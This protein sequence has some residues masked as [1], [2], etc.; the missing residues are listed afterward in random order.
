MGDL[1]IEGNQHVDAGELAEWKEHFDTPGS[2][3]TDQQHDAW[4]RDHSPGQPN[5]PDDKGLTTLKRR[6]DYFL[7]G[8]HVPDRFVVQHMTLAYNLLH[9]SEAFLSDHFGLNVDLYFK[10]PHCNPLDA[11]VVNAS[12]DFMNQGSFRPGQMMWYRFDEPGTYSFRVASPE[13][14]GIAFEV[15]ARTD[16][17]VPMAQY[18]QETTHFQQLE[19]QK[20]VLT[21]APFYVRVFSRRRKDTGTF[22]FR[23]HRHEGRIREDAIHLPP[24][25]KRDYEF[26]A[27]APAPF[28]LDDPITPWDEQDAVWFA[29]DTEGTETEAFQEVLFR[30]ESEKDFILTMILLSAKAEPL[31]YIRQAGPLPSPVEM[32]HAER[33]RVRFYLLVKRNDPAFAKSKFSIE[34][35]TN[36][37]ILHGHEAGLPGQPLMIKCEDETNPEIGS[38]D[39]AVRVHV[40]GKL[41][42]TITNDEIGDFDAGDL[43]GLHPFIKSIRYVDKVKFE[44]AEEDWLSDDDIGE[45]EVPS[46]KSDEAQKLDELYDAS[47]DG[48]KYQIRCNRS[49]WSP[50]KL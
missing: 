6:L 48:G 23:A 20:Y 47:F 42:K 43:K 5:T 13:A 50:A 1:N 11:L 28:T 15:Y 21:E 44:I 38:D 41:W 30:L 46:L 12:P 39:I 10:M 40:D 16:L 27:T 25:F 29:L 19:F 36:L 34:W 4:V 26:P 31:K 22:E 45:I 17:T 14:R 24:Y 18:K 9:P 7:H 49:R 32:D 37:T 3:Y 2:R 8:Q 35:A 33:H